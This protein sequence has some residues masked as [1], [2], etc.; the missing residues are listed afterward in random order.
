MEKCFSHRVRIQF[1]SERILFLN[2]R[3]N[4]IKIL[5]NLLNSILFCGPFHLKCMNCFKDDPDNSLISNNNK[6]QR[7]T[8]ILNTLITPKQMICAQL[9]VTIGGSSFWKALYCIY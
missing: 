6:Y 7:V 2:L 4:D 3:M 8:K 1:H 9:A 5:I